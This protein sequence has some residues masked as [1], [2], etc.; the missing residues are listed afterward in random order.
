M[1]NQRAIGLC[2]VAEKVLLITARMREGNIF[3]L[4]TLAGGG[5]GT[6]PM[7]GWGTP[8]QVWTGGGGG[9]YPILGLEGGT[10]SCWPGGTTSKIRMGEGTHPSR[11]GWGTPPPAWSG[12]R[13]AWR[14]LATRRAVCH[15]HSRRTFLFHKRNTAVSYSCAKMPA[16]SDV[17]DDTDTIQ[18]EGDKYFTVITTNTN[19][20]PK[21]SLC[22]VRFTQQLFSV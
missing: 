16:T 5:R 7:S 9:W 4:F 3:S 12:D 19:F 11:I 1:L 13:S 17:L 2:T 14:A 18:S 8:S 6:Y 10:S 22:V 15:L 20:A 21:T